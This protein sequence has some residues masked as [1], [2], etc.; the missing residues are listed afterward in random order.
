MSD[1]YLSTLIKSIQIKKDI[2]DTKRSKIRTFETRI[3]QDEMNIVQEKI[4]IDILMDE[5]T[6]LDQRR[7]EN[8]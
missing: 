7:K 5:I 3:Q 6:F 2:V 4:E 8:E 1:N